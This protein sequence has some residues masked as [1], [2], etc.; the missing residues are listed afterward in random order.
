MKVSSLRRRLLAV[1]IA[2]TALG[3][4]ATGLV[5][6]LD[7]RHEAHELFDAHLAQ[8]ASLLATQASA[9][10]EEVDTE[11]VALL[12]RHSRKTA[13]QIWEHGRELRLHSANAPNAR[14]SE[15]DE[16]FSDVTHA[17]IA[18][19]VFSAWDAG[20]EYLVQVAE[21]QDTRDEIA[22][23]MARSLALSLL[24]VLPLLAIALW[25]AVTHGLRPLDRLTRE[26]AQREPGRLVPLHAEDAP[27]EV[28]PLVAELNGLFA[29]IEEVLGRERRFTA[30]A[31]HELRTPLAALRTQAQLARAARSES[32]RE[33]ALDGILAGTDRATRLVEQLLTLARLESGAADSAAQP[34]ELRELVRAEIAAVAPRALAGGIDVEF[35]GAAAVTVTGYAGLLSVLA[36]NL[37][38]NAVRY[39]PQGGRLRVL[40]DA[41]GGSARLR[42]CNSGAVVAPED[43][44]RLGERFYR[45]AGNP[46]PGS[47]L[48]LS[49]VMRIAEQHGG[50]VAISAGEDGG[51]CVLVALPAVR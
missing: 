6:Y 14:L 2:T 32:V 48:G 50:T 13:F 31:A 41:S 40:V 36:R 16:G 25:L 11:H 17:G 28:R 35:E 4:L 49:I 30:D 44:S 27:V 42:V 29:R 43:I 51:L 26:L 18:W 37:L 12:H 7:A 21:R 19:R 24:G 38:D 8:T 23:A 22:G 5:G 33:E 47:G 20:H 10:T 45:V 1:L 34:L 9:E 46:A 39:T 15:L 3:W